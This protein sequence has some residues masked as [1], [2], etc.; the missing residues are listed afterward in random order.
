MQHLVSLTVSGV[1][2]A[3]FLQGYVTCDLDN[4]QPKQGLLMALTEIKGRVIAN[5]WC[6][7]TTTQVSLVFHQSLVETVKNHLGR[8]ITFAKS[9]FSDETIKLSLTAT[10]SEGEVELTPFGW[11][12]APSE[13]TESKLNQLTVEEEFPIIQDVTSGM[14]LPQMLNL[15]QHGAVSFTKG[16]YLGQE[17]VARAEHRGQVKRRVFRTKCLEQNVSVGTNVRVSDH[18]SCTVVGVDQDQVLLVGRRPS[19]K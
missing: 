17:I 3:T 9:E 15:T 12:L 13:H 14:F 1:D 2:S 18:G 16:C 8:Y 7:G 10:V 19:S 4:I 6:F 5:G 11:G